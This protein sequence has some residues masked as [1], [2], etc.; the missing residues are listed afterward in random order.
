V[1][2]YVVTILLPQPVEKSDFSIIVLAGNQSG[3]TSAKIFALPVEI[4]N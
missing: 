1:I 2:I 4:C 3:S